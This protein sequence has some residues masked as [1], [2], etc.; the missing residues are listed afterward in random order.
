MTLTTVLTLLYGRSIFDDFNNGIDSPLSQESSMA[1][2]SLMTLTT[3]LTLLYG[4]SIFDDFNN[5]ID[6]PLWQE[7]L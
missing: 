5:G 4:R 6:S 7:Y 2:V 1:G 3:V